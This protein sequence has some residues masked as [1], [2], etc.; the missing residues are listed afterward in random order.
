MIR[1]PPPSDRI[2]RAYLRVR[3]FVLVIGIPQAA[4]GVYLL[5]G[6]IS[7]DDTVITAA[8]PS[9]SSS[10]PSSSLSRGAAWWWLRA[11][12]PRHRHGSN[13]RRS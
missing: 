9:W 8:E 3:L 12:R 7:N 1:P 4:I 11:G 13:G 10:Q 2:R 6:G 5:A